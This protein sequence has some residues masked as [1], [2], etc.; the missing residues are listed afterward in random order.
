MALVLSHEKAEIP[1]S[2]GF[3]SW[4]RVARELVTGAKLAA[5]YGGDHKGRPYSGIVVGA[6]LVV[7]PDGCPGLRIAPLRP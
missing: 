1:C 6:T 2:D 5:V 3:I 4:F 7:A